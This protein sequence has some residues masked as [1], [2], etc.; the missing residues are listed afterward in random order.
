[1]HLHVSQS[2][3]NCKCHVTKI[4]GNWWCTKTKI[5]KIVSHVNVGNIYSQKSA[6]CPFY[7]ALA[8]PSTCHSS[9]PFFFLGNPLLKSLDLGSCISYACRI[10]CFPRYTSCLCCVGSIIIYEQIKGITTSQFLGRKRLG[11]WKKLTRIE[12]VC[13]RFLFYKFKRSIWF[14][15][16]IF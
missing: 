14:M 9:S 15:S 11:N 13:F 7:P 10:F 16:I 8:E 6:K 1:M 12:P 5:E 3:G 4:K 2:H